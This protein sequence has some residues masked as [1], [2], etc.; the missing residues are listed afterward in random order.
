MPPNDGSGQAMQVVR[1]RIDL[2]RQKLREAPAPVKVIGVVAVLVLVVMTPFLWGRLAYLIVVVPL[3]YGPVALVRRSRSVLASVGVGL[4]GLAIISIVAAKVEQNSF[5]AVPLLLLPVGA[6]LAAHARPLARAFVPCRTVALV[7]AWSLPPAIV[8]W[9]LD[10]SQPVIAYLIAWG[11]AVIVL[12]WRLGKA[13]QVARADTRQ[14][15]RAAMI[16]PYGTVGTAAGRAGHAAD[17]ARAFRQAEG[18][19]GQAA[20]A[21][22]RDHAPAGQEAVLMTG[23]QTMA[24][25][26]QMT[27]L[28][29]VKDQMPRLTA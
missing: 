20:T 9:W 14:R 19:R 3:L 11:L 8:A 29:P 2:L 4:W 24:E 16:A 22:P 21:A 12:G 27:G 1:E 18:A 17:Q 13:W 28:A 26:D 7:L 15:A 5:D 25:L 10:R 6:V 23:G